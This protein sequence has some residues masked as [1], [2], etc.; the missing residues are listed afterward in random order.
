MHSTRHVRAC[1]SCVRVERPDLSRGSRAER[2]TT[3]ASQ[4]RLAS[5]RLALAFRRLVA[6]WLVGGPVDSAHVAWILTPVLRRL[7]SYTS[8]ESYIC[9]KLESAT[10]RSRIVDQDAVVARCGRDDLHLR[11]GRVGGALLAHT[12][13]A[14]RAVEVATVMHAFTR[15]CQLHAGKAAAHTTGLATSRP[16]VGCEGCRVTA[17]GRQH[18]GSSTQQQSAQERR[19]SSAPSRAEAGF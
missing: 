17:L 2:H 19:I 16:A 14:D 11:G 15:G 1:T 6:R 13:V 5:R 18:K 4:R 8:L 9:R 7:S 10:R 12:I 3:R